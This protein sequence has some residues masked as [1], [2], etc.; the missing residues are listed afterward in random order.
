MD[1]NGF[2]VLSYF[3]DSKKTKIL[4]YINNLLKKKKRKKIRKERRI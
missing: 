1:M 4:R 2:E 3:K